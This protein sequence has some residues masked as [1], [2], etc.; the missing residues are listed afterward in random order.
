MKCPECSTPMINTPFANLGGDGVGYTVST[1][2]K[3][4]AWGTEKVCPACGYIPKDEELARALHV[5]KKRKPRY[6]A[7]A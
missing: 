2:T 3:R 6:R 1:H 5:R 7:R 4:P